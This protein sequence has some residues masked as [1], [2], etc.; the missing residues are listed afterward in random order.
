MVAD[1]AF[2]FLE[3]QTEEKADRTVRITDGERTQQIKPLDP[4]YRPEP[5][6]IPAEANPGTVAGSEDTQRLNLSIQRL[7]EAKKLLQKQ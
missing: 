5:Q 4:N 1:D 3:K 6:Q 7:Q 2:S